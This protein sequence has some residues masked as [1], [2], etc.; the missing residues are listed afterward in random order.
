MQLTQVKHTQHSNQDL[1]VESMRTKS[2]FPVSQSPLIQDCAPDLEVKPDLNF[3]IAFS[4]ARREYHFQFKLTD[5]TT[6][7]TTLSAE[8]VLL[9]LSP[10]F[11][12]C[13][14]NYLT[15]LHGGYY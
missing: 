13:I 7:C 14:F 11:I 2:H 6:T 10:T 4:R 15:I 12:V 8:P 3:P 5:I 9:L 1:F